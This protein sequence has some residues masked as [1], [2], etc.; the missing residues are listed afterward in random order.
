MALWARRGI[1]LGW[2]IFKSGTYVGRI[3]N[4]RNLK[5]YFFDYHVGR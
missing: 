1:E 4:R 2:F 5:M 3:E